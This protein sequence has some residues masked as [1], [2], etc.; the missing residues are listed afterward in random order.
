LIEKERLED[1]TERRGLSFDEMVDYFEATVTRLFI[2]TR[3]GIA[4]NVISKHVEWEREDLF[5]V[6]FDVLAST[7]V[8]DVSRKLTFRHDYGLFGYTTYVY[9]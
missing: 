8:R 4:F 6:P 5:H 7:L 1:F 9:R 2:R 3:I